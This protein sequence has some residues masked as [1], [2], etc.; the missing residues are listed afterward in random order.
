MRPLVLCEGIQGKGILYLNWASLGQV[1]LPARWLLRRGWII[2]KGRRDGKDGYG[3]H[4][5][6]LALVLITNQ[7]DRKE[8]HPLDRKTKQ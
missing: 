5:D 4:D 6:L 1:Y 8:G 2:R 3:S 7:G